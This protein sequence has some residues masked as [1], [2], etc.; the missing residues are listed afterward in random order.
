MFERFTKEARNVVV[1]AQEEARSLRHGWIGTEHLLLA[2][3]RAPGDPGV[4]TL[5]RLGVTADSCRSA[6]SGVVSARNGS[7][8][9]E[10]AEALRTLGIDLD[11]V[12]RKA[13]EAF[14]PGALEEP[15]NDP[16]AEGRSRN[17][18]LG[19]LGGLGPLKGHIP[20]SA[21][22]KKAME[23]TLREA[24]ARNDRRIGVEHLMLALLSA[25]DRITRAVFERLG[26]VP[27]DVRELVLAD[28][29]QAA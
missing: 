15:L 3:L 27:G 12:A 25:D 6:V 17:G 26:I 22:A 14:G 21:R 9:P 1:R 2:A 7:L 8:G 28:L 11:Q 20:F 29:R 18:P 4:A 5:A 16:E 23:V 19:S 24:V 13:R 10:D